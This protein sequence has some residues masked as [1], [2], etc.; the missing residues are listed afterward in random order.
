M[1]WRFAPQAQATP[2]PCLPHPQLPPKPASLAADA[3]FA[4]RVEYALW[5]KRHPD[6][7]GV[8]AYVRFYLPQNYHVR[9]EAGGAGW[10]S[11]VDACSMSVTPRVAVSIVPVPLDSRGPFACLAPSL[12]SR[13][14]SSRCSASTRPLRPTTS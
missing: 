1:R 6:Y 9:A 3:T 11:L 4:Q 8:E 7:E 13:S 10:R 14:W 2:Y 12:A 5:D